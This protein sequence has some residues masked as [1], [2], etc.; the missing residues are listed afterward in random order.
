MEERIQR[1]KGSKFLRVCYCGNSD[2]RRVLGPAPFWFTVLFGDLSEI[3]PDPNMKKNVRTGQLRKYKTSR[4]QNLIKAKE[5]GKRKE[6]TT[7]KT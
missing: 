6:W 5:G 4:A 3:T 1:S 2:R 7:P